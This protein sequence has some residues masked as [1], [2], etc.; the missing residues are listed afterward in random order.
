MTRM[1]TDESILLCKPSV[2]SV[3]SE[4][5]FFFILSAT[6]IRRRLRWS[7]GTAQVFSKGTVKVPR[8]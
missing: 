2:P 1:G 6:A 3:S 5:N 8:M 7:L 4:V